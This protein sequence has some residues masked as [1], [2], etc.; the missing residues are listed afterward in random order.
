MPNGNETNL[1]QAGHEL[2]SDNDRRR[3]VVALCVL[4][5]SIAVLFALI[6]LSLIPWPA[7][8]GIAARFQNIFNAVVPLIGTWIGTV[9]T[10]YF[11][12]ENFEAANRSMQNVITNLTPQQ[13][14]QS[15]NVKDIMLSEDK[16]TTVSLAAGGSDAD[17]KLSDLNSLLNQTITRIPILEHDKVKRYIIH[18]SVITRYFTDNRSDP[19]LDSKTLADLI[20]NP[21]VKAMV[22]KI[23]FVGINATMA[24]AKAAMDAIPGCQD[25]FVTET[26]QADTPVRGFIMNT[27]IARC[28]EL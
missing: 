21:S 2:S 24:D 23:G 14:L 20:S 5:M 10:F 6:L 3:Y 28:A 7:D 26:G 9:I 19:H 13:K 27:H 17:I 22:E 16:A 18:N 25:V 11:T 15:K 8:G 1:T 12:R 4:S